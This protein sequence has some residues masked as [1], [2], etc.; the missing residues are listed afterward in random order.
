VTWAQVLYGDE[1]TKKYFDGL[2][3]HWY[4]GLNTQHLDQTHHIAPDKF[5]LA[6]EACNCPGVK[7]SK[8]SDEWWSRAEKIGIDI[9]EDIKWWSVGWT[10]WNLMVDT[11][12]G[13]N[14]AANNC[15]ANIV[16]D[17]EN[18][19]GYGTVVLQASYYYMGHFS[20]F[21]PRGSKRI[22]MSS[23]LHVQDKMQ[24]KDVD[25]KMLQFVP[26]D[27]NPAQS[28]HFDNELYTLS[29]VALPDYC[30]E[31]AAD[32][33]SVVMKPCSGS[34]AQ[35]WT[36]IANGSQY[37]FENIGSHLCL[38]SLLTN[39][40]RIGLDPGVDGVA[41][42]VEKCGVPRGTGRDEKIQA[43]TL[44]G[45]APDNFQISTYQGCML[46]VGS[47]DVKFDSVAF[48]TREGTI[49]MIAMNKKDTSVEFDIYD[50][51]AKGGYRAVTVP[52][53]SITT[54][55]WPASDKDGAV[56]V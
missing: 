43:F 4:G 10:D 55:S 42:F 17:P 1:G 50:A 37:L 45:Q 21:L 3:V 30:A 24:K 20:R 53:H 31:V 47:G 36:K 48:R 28:W 56:Y 6:T 18:K 52:P 39:G 38:T 33:E 9:L 54:F 22:G 32:K 34:N 5:I 2:G 51:I 7:Y 40:D 46:P 29:L 15:D 8:D 13:P 23:T 44:K 26:C 27:N 49:S 16:C 12:G 14:H 41:G 35:G 11:V 19:E 25:S